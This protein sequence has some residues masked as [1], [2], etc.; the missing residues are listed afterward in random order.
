MRINYLTFLCSVNE[1]QYERPAD[2][3]HV[4][5]DVISSN[6]NKCSLLFLLLEIFVTAK[7]HTGHPIEAAMA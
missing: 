5:S 1:C 7:D 2:A 3:L 6:E 4:R